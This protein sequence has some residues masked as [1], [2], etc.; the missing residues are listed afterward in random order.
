MTTAHTHTHIAL[1]YACK[2]AQ[3]SAERSGNHEQMQSTQTCWQMY[4][5]THALG[6]FAYLKHQAFN[7]C[8]GSIG[9]SSSV[10][11]FLQ[12]KKET[13]QLFISLI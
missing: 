2:Q 5:R 3:G 4:S 8:M 9:D 6:C 11:K 10:P 7:L 13:S 12:S 1:A